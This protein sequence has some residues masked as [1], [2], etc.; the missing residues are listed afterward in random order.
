M[1]IIFLGGKNKNM[2]NEMKYFKLIF[3]ITIASILAFFVTGCEK[4]EKPIVTQLVVMSPLPD[5]VHVK[6]ILRTHHRHHQ[7]L[8]INLRRAQ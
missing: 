8:R 4:H 1:I 5:T 2:R 7:N 6:I 3:V